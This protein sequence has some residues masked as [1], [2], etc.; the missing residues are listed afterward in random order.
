MAVISSPSLPA[1]AAAAP[2][3]TSAATRRVSGVSGMRPSSASASSPSPS[4][5]LPASSSAR[6]TMASWWSGCWSRTWRSEASSPAASRAAIFSSSSLGSRLS[7]NSRTAASGW[8]PT[9][10]STTLPSATAYT[11]GMPCTWNAWETCGFSSTFTLTSTT[12]P[13]VSSTT[14]S[15]IG[16][17]RAARAAPRCPQVDD[18]G[19]GG[20]PVEDVG[21]ERGVGDV[22]AHRVRLP[23]DPGPPHRPRDPGTLAPTAAVDAVTR[24]T[25]PPAWSLYGEPP[26]TTAPTPATEAPKGV[27]VARVTAWFQAHAP[28]VDAA[29]VLRADRGRALEPHLPGDRRRRP[30]LGAAPPAARPGAGHRPRHGPRAPHHLGAGADRR[31]RGAGRRAVRRTRRS[32]APRS[33]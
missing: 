7:T 11:A 15:R 5:G 12:L 22:D 28:E 24:G 32:T 25:R 19:G 18:D 30:R 9:N 16:P 17:E 33:T 3:R 2:V 4:S 14:F 10:P 6:A 13:S 26:M 27:D 21:L 20:R 29:A 8:A 1:S 31:A 23:A